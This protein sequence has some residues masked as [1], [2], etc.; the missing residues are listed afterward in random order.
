[1]QRGEMPLR[2]LEQ[3][4]LRGLAF[5][6]RREP[7]ETGRLDP[8]LDDGLDHRLLVEDGLIRTLRHP[9]RIADLEDGRAETDQIARPGGRFL[10]RPL[11]DERP[12]RGVEVLDLQYAAREGDRAMAAREPGAGELQASLRRAA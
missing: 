11:I 7:V 10:D 4:Q 2:P 9:G 6:R 12:L 3:R 8:P 1:M 5:R